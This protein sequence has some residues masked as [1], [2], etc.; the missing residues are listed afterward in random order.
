[1]ARRRVALWQ[2]VD[3][4]HPQLTPAW[5]LH[6]LRQE[7]D[8]QF[9]GS[10][11]RALA[12]L[13][14]PAH[15]AVLTL[16]AERSALPAQRQVA[17][18]M[19]SLVF[20]PP[21]AALLL[22]VA[23]CTE[24]APEVRAAAIAGLGDLRPTAPV[25]LLCE[26]LTGDEPLFRSAAAHALGRSAQQA[27]VSPLL[28]AFSSADDCLRPAIAEAL[29][30]LAHMGRTIA[31]APLLCACLDAVPAVRAFA[32]KAL[33]SLTSG[34]DRQITAALLRALADPEP[35]VRHAVVAGVEQRPWL[36]PPELLLKSLNDASL[37]VRRAAQHHVQHHLANRQVSGVLAAYDEQERS[38]ECCW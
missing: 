17:L 28:A 4:H 8:A 20:P 22:A 19:L 6:T 26:I 12:A 21:P 14:A 27:A 2:L 5:L 35:L 25:S 18:S 10:L 33:I 3:G 11:V 37:F 34:P 9:G 13:G 15:Q 7:Q 16:A 31:P 30:L 38:S 23:T 1:M 36:V 24:E 32:L 29:W